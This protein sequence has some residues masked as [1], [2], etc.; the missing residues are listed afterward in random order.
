MILRRVEIRNFRK[1]VSPVTLEDLPNGLVVVAGGNEDGKSTVLEALRAAFLYKHSWSGSL[2]DTLQPYGSAV[3]PEVTVEFELPGGHYRIHKGFCQRKL[4]ELVTPHGNFEGDSA[5]DELATLLG[6][7]LSTRAPRSADGIEGGPLGLLWVRQGGAWSATVSTSG[8]EGLQATLR[9]QVGEVLGGTHAQ[10]ILAKVRAERDALLTPKDA[11]P[12]GNL[13]AA[14][15]RRSKLSS[16]LEELKA[17]IRSHDHLRESLAAAISRLAA[18]R[19]QLP[20]MNAALAEAEEDSALAS[21]LQAK[22]NAARVER[23]SSRAKTDADTQRL[24]S[25]ESLRTQ[26]AGRAREQQERATAIAAAQS[27]VQGAEADR[28][29]KLGYVEEANERLKAAEARLAELEIQAELASLQAQQAALHGSMEK[30]RSAQDSHGQL[31][32]AALAIPVDKKTIAKL[33]Q[34]DRDLNTAQA[35]LAAASTHLQLRLSEGYSAQ[36]N[37]TPTANELSSELAKRTEIVIRAKNG[38]VAWI[39]L[40]PSAAVADPLADRDRRQSAWSA[41]ARKCQVATLAEAEQRLQER[42]QHEQDATLAQKDLDRYAPDGLETLK[43]QAHLFQ[44][45]ITNLQEQRTGAGVP[46]GEL[47]AARTRAKTQAGAA[48]QALSDAVSNAK[49][50]EANFDNARNHLVT[51]EN[52]EQLAQANLAAER[53]RLEQITGEVSDAELNHRIAAERTA[54]GALEA[55]CER[56]QQEIEGKDPKR[57]ALRLQMATQAHQHLQGEIANLQLGIENQRGQLAKPEAWGEQLQAVETELAFVNRRYEELSQRA[58]ALQLLAETLEQA[59]AQADAKFLAPVTN[60]VLPL[61]RQ[62]LPESEI[63]LDTDMQVVALR[64]SGFSE[65]FDGLSHGT[66]EQIAVLVRLA[67]AELLRR[68]GRPSVVILDDAPAYADDTRFQSM[69]EIL[70]YTAQ[71]GQILIFTCRE[72]DFRRSGAPIFH[73]S[74]PNQFQAATG[75]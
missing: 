39:T 67:F 17:K 23:E 61:L 66:R 33:R 50:A 75:R 30:A 42:L 41:A 73:L 10:A 25:R 20:E 52:E 21:E 60:C 74:A 46:A 1:L 14:A 12:R 68:R 63:E 38:E 7:S 59:Q 6:T 24:Q 70:H 55:T 72:R 34:L 9:Q 19:A 15:D 26:I 54:A 4:A 57:T 31:A 69:L 51:A 27:A 5:E 28:Q 36:L 48:R 11:A 49:L 13:K 53:Q 29:A 44:L 16:E 35:T 56:L 43:T 45:H 8:R 64:R 22:C 2:I 37:D 62:L 3:R 47:G 32:A 40:V 58:R 65:P 18:Y 71:S